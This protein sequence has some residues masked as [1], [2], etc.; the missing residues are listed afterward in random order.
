MTRDCFYFFV[1]NLVRRFTNEDG[2]SLN[3]QTYRSFDKGFTINNLQK[4]CFLSLQA[5][6]IN[7]SYHCR[8]AP[9]LRNIKGLK[10]FLVLGERKIFGELAQII[11]IA[12]ESNIIMKIMFKA[13]SDNDE[14]LTENMHAIRALE[15]KSDEI[16]FK[17]SEDIMGGAVS[18]NI[19]DNLIESVQVSDDIVDLYY[20]L[21]RELCR[22]SRANPTDF[23]IHEEAQ[24]VSI[25]ENMFALAD[26]SLSRLQQMLS[27]DNVSEILNLRKEV[28]S[29]E[30]QGDD[31]KDAG[32]DRLYGAAP[33]LHFL[34]FYH[35]SELLH[36]CDDIL[37]SCEDLSDLIV[38]VVTSILK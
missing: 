37:D 7:I 6:Y 16:A 33:R 23:T 11:A 22:M 24:W 8:C 15:K 38:S 28:E 12:A 9:L 27:T 1:F 20:Y 4:V 10:G 25:Y 30:E 19:I 17:L 35:Y 36:K 13:S 26:K 31:I 34:Q 2:I 29:L 14:L 3:I 32:F 5:L 18:P 21:S